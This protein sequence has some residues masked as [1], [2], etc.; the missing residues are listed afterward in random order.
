MRLL[1]LLALAIGLHAQTFEVASVKLRAPEARRSRPDIQSVPGS[2]TMSNVG[3][4][5]AIIWSCELS[6]WQIPDNTAFG[7][8]C[9]EIQAKASGPAS[10]DQMHAMMRALLAERFKLKLHRATKEV[11]GYA[12]LEAKSGHKMKVS[13]SA[14]GPGVLDDERHAALTGKCATLDQRAVMLA[15]PLHAPVVDLTGLKGRFDFEFDVTEY[16]PR[17]PRQPGEP[18]PDPVAILQMALPKQL[19]L[20][21]EARRLPIEMLIIDHVVTKPVEN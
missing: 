18:E 3:L 2:V 10:A 19:G 17:G 15:E 11:S 16:L 7:S 4:Q 5:H 1:A 9:F 21:L 20:R 6:P 13:A 8:E 14:E 12:L